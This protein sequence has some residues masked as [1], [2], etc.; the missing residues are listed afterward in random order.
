PSSRWRPTARPV[1]P[2]PRAPPRRS[3]SV[4]CWSSSSAS[5]RLKSAG[6]SR[7]R[8][9]RCVADL[10]LRLLREFLLGVVPPLRERV[11]LLLLHL[12]LLDR[13]LDLVERDRGRL[14]RLVHGPDR[15]DHVPAELRVH[16]LGDLVRLQGKRGLLEGRDGLQRAAD[17]LLLANGQAA[18]RRLARIDRVLEREL[19]EV[20]AGL[21]LV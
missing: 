6:G 18:A 17:R 20:A 7:R 14:T 9:W 19:R 4:S 15:L 11:L 8:S 12:L 5:E 13:R 2:P 3:R 21:E 16:R 10:V 1:S